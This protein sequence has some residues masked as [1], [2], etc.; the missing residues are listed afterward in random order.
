MGMLL[1]HGKT[2]ARLAR[3][4]PCYVCTPVLQDP[5]ESGINSSAQAGSGKPWDGVANTMSQKTDTMSPKTNVCVG[6]LDVCV[7]RQTCV[8]VRETPTKAK[9]VQG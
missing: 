8:C 9:A 6:S 1:P 3:P 5:K 7:C 4:F 2:H